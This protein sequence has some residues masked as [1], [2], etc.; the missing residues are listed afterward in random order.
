MAA[1]KNVLDLRVAAAN[2][3]ESRESSPSAL[4]CYRRCS[5]KSM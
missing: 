5:G 3:V 2:I 4:P 1:N